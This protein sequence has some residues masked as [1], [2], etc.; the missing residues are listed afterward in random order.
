MAG[1]PRFRIEVVKGVDTGTAV[2]GG[3][4]APIK[5]GRRRDNAMV[6]KDLTVS[7]EHACIEPVS[8]GFRI[9]DLNSQAG[10]KRRGERIP[11]D[12][13]LLAQGD[14][15]H[16]GTTVI[17]FSLLNGPKEPREAPAPSAGDATVCEPMPDEP[18]KPRGPSGRAPTPP[19]RPPD[20]AGPAV[21]PPRPVRAPAGLGDEPTIESYGPFEVKRAIDATDGERLDL[22]V[23]T[24][25]GTEVVLRRVATSR[26][27]WL[28][29]RRFVR[30]CE[31][32]K[33]FDHPNLAAPADFGQQGDAVYVAAAAGSHV[34]AEELL[35]DCPKKLGIDLAVWIGRDVA[36]AVA[37]VAER[38]GAA[39]R[40]EVGSRTVVV[41]GRGEVTLLALGPSAGA[42]KSPDPVGARYRAP[43]EEG[44]KEGG[45]QA[46]VFSTGVLLYELL[47]R[48]PIEP[49][50]KATLRNI[51]TVRID[52]PT[53]L[54]RVVMRAVE[55]R[56]EDRGGADE[57]AAAL[58]DELRAFAPDF[59]Q[60]EV[61]AFLAEYFPDRSF[62]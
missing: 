62:R 19:R 29:R 44:G 5:I 34:M 50:H 53:S 43:E 52:V 51:D 2:E 23:D 14:E 6:L 48:E 37:Y 60:G 8:R 20:P 16:L 57:L 15:L 1:S 11:P 12:G 47:A 22:A 39:A 61:A 55:P 58:D 27:G 4:D 13:A 36:R 21:R 30:I 28:G 38:R 9:R 3:V 54:G 41:G 59:G 32:W 17:R 26:L 24:R 18:R 45:V 49:R 33:G 42:G 40:L 7:R 56:P 10:I 46:A 25:G 31:E 35:R